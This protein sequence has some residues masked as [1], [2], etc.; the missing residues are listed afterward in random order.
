MAPNS[1]SA[2]GNR[3]LRAIPPPD[4]EALQSHL[5]IVELPVRQKL[6]QP[7]S[8]VML[9]LVRLSPDASLSSPD[10]A[11]LIGSTLRDRVL[12]E[13]NGTPLAV[14]DA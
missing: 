6:E 1:R 4:L 9:R 12:S 14:G 3:I 7:L 2:N 11:S 5:T 10:G 8:T 13:A